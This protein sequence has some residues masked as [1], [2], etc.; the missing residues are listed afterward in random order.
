MSSIPEELL[1]AYR[2]AHFHVFSEPPFVLRIGEHSKG[3]A[4]LHETAG[5]SSSAFITAYNPYSMECTEEQNL[6]AQAR[7]VD[8]ID[9]SGL[10]SIEGEGKDPEGQWPGEPSLLVLGCTGKQAEDLGRLYKQNA[11]VLCG[12]DAVPELVVL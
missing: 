10:V 9:K 4:V 1:A 3:L 2:A 5:V 8:S 12:D 6:A 7:L 11:V